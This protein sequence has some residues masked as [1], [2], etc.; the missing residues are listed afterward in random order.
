MKKFIEILFF[1]PKKDVVQVSLLVTL[2]I[3]GALL[4]SL[5]IG[6]IFPVISL[7]IGGVEQ[8]IDFNFIKNITTD[9]QLKFIIN[10]DSQIL[11][12]SALAFLIIIYFI[13]NFFLIIV[14]KYSH[15]TIY[16]FQSNLSFALLKKYLSHDYNFFL[17]NDQSSLIR[18]IIDECA[19]F[20]KRLVYPAC[21]LLS[22][23]FTLIS[24]F[25]VLLFINFEITLMILIVCILLSVVIV[26]LT[27]KKIN[28]LASQRLKYSKLKY[29][30]LLETFSLILEVKI[31]NIENVFLKRFFIS[32]EQHINADRDVDMINLFHRQYL[33]FLAVLVFCLILIFSFLKGQSANSTLPLIGLY[34]S[35]AFRLLPSI[36]RILVYSNNFIYGISAFKLINQEFNNSYKFFDRKNKYFNNPDIKNISNFENLEFNDVDFG[37]NENNKIL[38]NI[39]LK[40]NRGEAIAI[41]GESGVGKSTVISLML[42][43]L[44]PK[45][46]TIKLNNKYNLDLNKINFFNFVGYVPQKTVLINDT[47]IKNIALGVEEKDIDYNKAKDLIEFCNLNSLFENLTHGLN[48]KIGDDGARLSGGQRQRIAICRA[49]Y[50]NPQFLILDEATSSLDEKNE[51]EIL[52]IIKKLKKEITLIFVSHK[53]SNI[54]ICDKIFNIKNKKLHLINENKN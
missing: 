41:I 7:L 36:N 44:S 3:I 24:I 15:K 19:N 25:V 20:I 42:G 23:I 49:L 51:L 37:Y 6:M 16:R 45:K 10:L 12:I 30:S 50:F 9:E 35:A 33:E 53:L 4:E 31:R 40:I 13:K 17:N 5:S 29:Q 18:N 54:K 32:N 2:F 27:K 38:S 43:L 21:F 48:I 8:L 52:N 28:F 14:Y 47:L 22:E 26:S 46:G 1:F 39:N 11:Y 34:A